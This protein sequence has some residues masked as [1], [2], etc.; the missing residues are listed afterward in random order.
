MSVRLRVFAGRSSSAGAVAGFA[1]RVRG[2]LVLDL[3]DDDL[4][5]DLEDCLDF[6]EWG[7]KPRCEEIEYL[8]LVREARD[9]M[10]R[11]W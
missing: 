8:R 11:G 1:E 4:G 5:E 7:S 10:S 2:E 9:R 3:P 6:Y